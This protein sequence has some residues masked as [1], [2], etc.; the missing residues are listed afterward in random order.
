MAIRMIHFASFIS[1]CVD[2]VI[3]SVSPPRE[4]KMEEPFI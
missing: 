3:L 4:E 2:V 1:V